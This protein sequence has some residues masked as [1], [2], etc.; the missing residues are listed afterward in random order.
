VQR[1]TF[2]LAAV[3]L[4][5]VAEKAPCRELTFSIDPNDRNSL[6]FNEMRVGEADPLS[7]RRGRFLSVDPNL[8]I[9]RSL[10]EPQRWNRYSYVVNNPV[11][12]IDP[13]GRAD[14]DLRCEWCNTPELRASFREGQ[15]QALKIGAAVAATYFVGRYSPAAARALFS[16][17][18]ANP[19]RATHVA[20]AILAPPGP[21]AS[22]GLPD[23]AKQLATAERVGTALAKSEVS[24]RAASFGLDAVAKAGQAFELKVETAW[25]GR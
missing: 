23:V 1:L 22:V 20:E 5:L 18:L 3:L 8:D 16:W 21:S 19:N 9:K 17:A 6:G 25:F 13:D 15:T 14:T 24:H 10:P 7:I 12:R 4:V 11:N 2:F